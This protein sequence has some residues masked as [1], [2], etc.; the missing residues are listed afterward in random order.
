LTE[1]AVDAARPL[2]LIRSSARSRAAASNA[3]RVGGYD[4]TT[5]TASAA[6]EKSKVNNA[7]GESSAIGLRARLEVASVSVNSRDDKS[8]PISGDFQ[9]PLSRSTLVRA[10]ARVSPPSS[11]MPPRPRGRRAAPAGVQAPREPGLSGDEKPGSEGNS[12]SESELDVDDLPTIDA[13]FPPNDDVR[14]PKDDPGC[15]FFHRTWGHEVRSWRLRDPNTLDQLR[16]G[17]RDGNVSKLVT[18][19]CVDENNNGYDTDDMIEMTNKTEPPHKHTLNL[20]FCYAPGAHALRN[21]MLSYAYNA[22]ELPEDDE[23]NGTNNTRV[24]YTKKYLKSPAG[25]ARLRFVND[26]DVGVYASPEGGTEASWHYDANHNITVQLYGSKTWYVKSGDRNVG[27]SRGAGDPPRNGREA[28]DR[29]PHDD[30]DDVQVIDLDPGDVVYIPPGAWHRVVPT[31]TD[32]VE[33]DASESESYMT[34]V[35]LSVDVRV[36][37]VTHARWTCESLFHEMTRH[38]DLGHGFSGRPNAFESQ[39]LRGTLD[40]TTWLGDKGNM[41]GKAMHMGFAHEYFGGEN[42]GFLWD[43]PRL[44]P[45]EPA[46]SNGMELRASLAYLV[47]ELNPWNGEFI[48]VGSYWKKSLKVV[49][50]P[51]VAVRRMS[52]EYDEDEDIEG[53]RD[54]EP[55]DDAVSYANAPDFILDLRATS[56]LTNMD[57][58]RMQI[59]L[60][61]CLREYAKR[62]V[63]AS[64]DGADNP[65]ADRTMGALFPEYLNYFTQKPV[66]MTSD[67]WSTMRDFLDVLVW[68]RF[69]KLVP[70]TEE[71][72]EEESESSKEEEESSLEEPE[73]SEV[74]TMP[75]S[76]RKKL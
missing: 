44:M 32:T 37:S 29:L 2:L 21:S 15:Q 56:G 19:D 46:L 53:T 8:L 26:I 28:T 76:K 60:P 55:K 3:P 14:Y 4:S 75:T 62:V 74:D 30:D 16:T 50:H 27:V 1:E 68:C 67:S 41:A 18:H 25:V 5:R 6:H 63:E 35:C 24:G 64:H 57:Y 13:I 48:K 34:D 70:E 59:V 51:M 12:R 71:S 43:P 11:G 47:R 72:S 17:F 10:P 73:Q 69:V 40:T 61:P 65:H 39:S 54:Y 22:P 58:C 20:P 45:Y 42:L 66:V 49:W 33:R 7:R 9:N 23:V 52:I 31:S 38:S 36:A